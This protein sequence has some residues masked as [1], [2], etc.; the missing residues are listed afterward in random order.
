MIY[1]K[2]LGLAVI[3]VFSDTLILDDDVKMLIAMVDLCY[4]MVPM[5]RSGS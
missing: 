5:S 2:E 4:R 3:N 1:S